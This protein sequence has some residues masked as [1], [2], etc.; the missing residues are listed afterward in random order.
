VEINEEKEII[1][2]TGVVRPQ[3]VQK[4]N[5]IYSSSIA[6]AQI[7]YAGKGVANTGRRPGFLAR[8]LNWI[9]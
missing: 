7:T 4:N 3:D 5:S 9:F 2:I 1:K 8:F 6:D